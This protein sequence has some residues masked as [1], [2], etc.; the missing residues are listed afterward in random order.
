MEEHLKL[1]NH[2]LSRMWISEGL[3]F[4]RASERERETRKERKSET[5]TGTETDFFG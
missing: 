1:Y 4:E 2:E 3:K 5:E